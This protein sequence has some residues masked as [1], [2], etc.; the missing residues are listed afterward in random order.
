MPE[1]GEVVQECPLR[2][3]KTWIEIELVGED[4]KP[5]PGVPYRILLVDGSTVEGALDET[6][7]ARVDDIDPG[8]CVVT[9]P[10]LDEEA[11]VAI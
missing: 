2:K 3:K 6:G 10:E 1:Y 7:S 9:F 5:I 11:W 8:T 4:D